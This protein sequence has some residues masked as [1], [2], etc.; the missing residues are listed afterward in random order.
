MG[1]TIDQ[2]NGWEIDN[3]KIEA[4]EV[5]AGILLRTAA[6]SKITNNTIAFLD[7]PADGFS[8]G[9]DVE[10]GQLNLVEQ[11]LVEGVGLSNAY[12]ISGIN[13]EGTLETQLSCNS[14]DETDI[15]ISVE[16]INSS[17]FLLTNF[18]NDHRNGL[19]YGR[20]MADGTING[21][22]ITPFQE[23][24]GNVWTRLNQNEGNSLNEKGAVHLGTQALVGQTLFFVDSDE[25]FEFLPTTELPN[26]NNVSWFVPEPN[27]E[28]TFICDPNT[29]GF[30]DNLIS[31]PTNLDEL[32]EDIRI[33]CKGTVNWLIDRQSYSHISDF[34][35]VNMM[36]SGMQQ[37]LNQMESTSVGRYYAVDNSIGSMLEKAVEPEDLNGFAQ[38]QQ[39]ALLRLAEIEQ[40]IFQTYLTSEIAALENEKFSLISDIRQISASGSQI[41]A[42]I[43][44]EKIAEASQLREGNLSI[45][46]VEYFEINEK[47]IRDIFLRTVAIGNTGFT[48][49]DIELLKTLTIECATCSGYSVFLARSLYEGLRKRHKYN[50]RKIGCKEGRSFRTLI[51]EQKVDFKVYPNPTNDFLIIELPQNVLDTTSSF[52]LFNHLGQIVKQIDLSTSSSILNVADLVDGIYLGTINNA[53]DNLPLQ[54]KIIINH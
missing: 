39:E 53:R 52:T 7:N 34:I 20:Y 45:P 46:T 28:E 37:F 48:N 19:L 8:Y 6:R 30:Q 54:Q 29:I 43:Q 50:D 10:G 51:Q 26:A 14:V 41:A 38:K 23:H 2:S 11:N 47:D 21:V 18:I 22:A 3:N 17:T 27:S 31:T 35:P 15:G 44:E 4:F 24:N 49:A 40:L 32:Y 12:K 36:S 16:G 42:N 5:Q 13:I 9:I 1:G 33:E 25:N